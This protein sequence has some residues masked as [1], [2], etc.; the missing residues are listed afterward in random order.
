MTNQPPLTPEIL[1]PRIGDYLVDKGL[2]SRQDLDHALEIQKQLRQSGK[3]VLVGQ[4][5]IDLGLIDRL[6]LDHAVTE[7][8]LVLRAAL[9]DANQQLEQRVKDRTAELQT[10]LRKLS[11]LNQLKSDMISNISHELRTP[12]THIKGYLELLVTGNLGPLTSAQQDALKI[13][14]KSSDR[15]KVLIDDLIRFSL[16][17]QGEFTLKFSQ[18]D[19]ASLCTKLID[20]I[21]S[22]ADEGQVSL[23]LVAEPLEPVKADEE[24]ISWI[25]LQLLDNAVKFTRPGGSVTVTLDR[26]GGF[27]RASIADTGIGIAP[28]RIAEIFEPFHQLDGTST[29][30]YGGTGLGLALVRQILDAHG[31]V[32]RVHSQVNKGTS[33]EF[34]LPF[35]D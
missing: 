22:K 7:Q 29:R 15:L 25:I 11:E 14:Q 8:I 23:H 5:L 6:S 34:V 13:I 35:A 30:R 3:E 33:F 20:Q 18:I 28:E 4:L 2:L 26:E 16:A 19:L 21:R 12:L 10:A 24:K 9:Q 27:A 1:V 31:S 17:S 32:I